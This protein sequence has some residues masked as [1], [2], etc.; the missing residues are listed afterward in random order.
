MIASHSN[1]EAEAGTQLVFSRYGNEY[2]LQRI[3]DPSTSRLNL[4]LVSS[5]SERKARSRQQEARL[6][7]AEP[8]LIAAR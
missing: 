8:V 5:K 7:S 4:D 1:H 3:L 2:F 6:P